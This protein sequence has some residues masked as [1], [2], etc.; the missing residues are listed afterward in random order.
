M[1]TERVFSKNATYQMFEVIRTNRNKRYKRRAFFVEGVR[2]INAAI[3]YGWSFAAF[4]YAEGQRLSAWATELLSSAPAEMNYVLSPA[5]MA[6]LSGKTDTS[7][8][9]AIVKMREDAL[10]QIPLSEHAPLIALFDRPSNRGNLGTLLRS[11][12]A[13]G[14]DGLLLT[15]H[16]VDLYDADVIAASMGSFFRVPV[17]R[18]ADNAMVEEYIRSLRDQ[19]ADFQVVGTTAHRK[20]TLYQA[21]LTRPTL[22]MLGNETQGLNQHLLS[23]CDELVTIPMAEGCDATSLNVSCAASILFAEAM[24]QRSYIEQEDWRGGTPRK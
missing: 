23:I 5:L 17:V 24:R 16:G 19:Y 11:C 3:R 21:D 9:L 10:Q 14:I 15:G 4:L 1:K 6:E 2:N 18:I 20:K 8:L 12:D 22:L 13:L 7:E